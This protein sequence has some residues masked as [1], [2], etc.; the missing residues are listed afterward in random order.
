VKAS[1][2]ITVPFS[3]EAP[4]MGY[5][6]FSSFSVDFWKEYTTFMCNGALLRCPPNSETICTITRLGPL[7]KSRSAFYRCPYFSRILKP[8]SYL[9]PSHS[10]LRIVN[11]HPTRLQKV[12]SSSHQPDASLIKHP[13]NQHSHGKPD[14]TSCGA[15][16]PT[17]FQI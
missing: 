12:P 14:L 9:R 5:Y 8:W 13:R 15:I 10:T 7:V 2:S 4:V 17:L 3:L 11:H 6:D 16:K 1:T